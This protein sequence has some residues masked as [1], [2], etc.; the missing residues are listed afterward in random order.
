MRQ[1]DAFAAVLF[2]LDGVLTSTAAQHFAAWKQMFDDFLSR[3]AEERGEPFTPFTADDYHQHVDGLPRYDGVR[4]FLAARGIELPEGEPGDPPDNDTV[5]GLGNRKNELVNDLIRTEGVEAYD[6]SVA[7]V[8]ALRAHG[9]RTA[10]VTSSRNGATILQAAGMEELF[11]VRVD[12]NTAAELGLAGKPAPDTFLEAARQLGIE[13]AR[14][15]VVEDALSGVQ[16]GRDG[17]FGLVVGVDRVGQTEA[18]YHHGA[19]VVV[20]DLAELLD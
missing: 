11:E 14:A 6:G 5:Q 8:H 9:V 13:P 19:D 12:G 4:R 15:A 20:T 17:G 7:L 2:D 1:L 16:A 18:L 3:R 10:V